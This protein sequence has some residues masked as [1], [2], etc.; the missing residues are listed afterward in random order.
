MPVLHQCRLLGISRSSAYYEP[1][2][3]SAEQLEIMRRIDQIHL[4]H[5]FYGSRKITLE[6]CASGFHVNRKRVQRLMRLMD[7]VPLYPKKQTSRPNQAHTIYPYLLRELSIERADQVW[8]TDIT[9]IPMEKGFAYLIAIIDWHSRKVLA[10]RMSNTMDTQFCLDALDE[11]LAKY[12]K[13][14]IFNTDQGSQFTSDAFTGR[15]KEMDIR[16]SMDGKGRWVDNVFIERLWRS[17][18]YEEVYIKAYGTI[19]E[20]ELAIG[21]YFVFYNEQRFHQGLN[22]HT[23][24]QVYFA[25]KKFAA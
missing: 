13:P 5:P 19:T 15:L 9:Y 1:A 2:P 6:L 12:G 25:K 14:E 8:A 20:A 4:K 17:L 24:D 7:I 16:I 10:W 23:P 21:E 22:N 11:A 18:K 3:F